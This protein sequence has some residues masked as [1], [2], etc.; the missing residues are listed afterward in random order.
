GEGTEG[1]DGIH[2]KGR[3]GLES[4]LLADQHRIVD[5]AVLGILPSRIAN[6]DRNADN[7]ELIYRTFAAQ[8]L[9]ER[10]FPAAGLAPA[11]PE[12]HHQ[13]AAL[14]VGEPML[15]AVQPGQCKLW[16]RLGDLTDRRGWYG[17]GLSRGGSR[18][19]GYGRGCG[20]Q[21]RARRAR[22]VV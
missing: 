7:F 16:Q 18:R 13:R 3:D 11:G 17:R 20:V 1:Q 2:S 21:P 12:I 10:N 5:S 14:P 8:G 15:R 9:Q 4:S 19:E 6:I 22:E